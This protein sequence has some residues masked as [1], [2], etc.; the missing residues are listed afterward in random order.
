MCTSICL[1]VC[2]CTT[3]V[4]KEDRGCWIPWNSS[5]RWLWVL[6]TRP[7]E[8]DHL[9]IPLIVERLVLFSIFKICLFMCMLQC[10][11]TQ[12]VGSHHMDVWRQSKRSRCL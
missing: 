7:Q 3:Y 2:M 1:H 6:G 5:Y 10:I 12:E 8:L 9:S 4:P 11:D